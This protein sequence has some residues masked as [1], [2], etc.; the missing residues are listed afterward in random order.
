MIR[1]VT[2]LEEHV[3]PQEVARRGSKGF[4]VDHPP[5]R[6][7]SIHLL[8]EGSRCGAHGVLGGGGGVVGWCSAGGREGRRAKRP[9]S[10]NSQRT[11]D[12]GGCSRRIRTPG[13]RCTSSAGWSARGQEKLGRRVR[14]LNLEREIVAGATARTCAVCNGPTAQILVGI[15]GFVA[16]TGYARDAATW[17]PAPVQPKTEWLNRVSAGKDESARPARLPFARRL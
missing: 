16:G 3:A 10:W 7:G 9:G 17:I 11:R 4:R 14:R 6:Q 1:T 8:S 15:G 12:G 2:A 5:P 13:G